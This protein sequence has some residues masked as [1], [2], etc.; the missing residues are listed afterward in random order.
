M[1]KIEPHHKAAGA[2]AATLL[3]CASLSACG[4]AGR[5]GVDST[6]AAESAAVTRVPAQAPAR[7]ES[8]AD[9]VSVEGMPQPMVLRLFRSPP[10]Y[11]L[12]FT[13][14]LPS[15]LAAV[16]GQ[17]PRGEAVRFEAR[18][19]GRP[20]PEIYLQVVAL[21]AGISEADA[22]EAAR[23]AA[24]ERG[25][26]EETPPRQPWS[27]AGFTYRGAGGI[28]GSVALGRHAGRWF[29]LVTHLPAEAADGFGPR[30]ARVLREWRW[31]DTGAPLEEGG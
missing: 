13:T 14:Y 20:N 16:A 11:P 6:P 22:R 4:E 30:T 5:P 9:T 7:P 27:S 26:A 21:P 24:S 18:F 10:G 2:G 17:S 19:G 12:G 1:M 28:I 29:Y 25:E 8:I 3:L 31:S 15:D 23:G